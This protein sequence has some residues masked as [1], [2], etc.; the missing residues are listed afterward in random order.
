LVTPD[1]GGCFNVDGCLQKSFQSK[2]GI[3]LLN[4]HLSQATSPVVNDYELF[5]IDDYH[6]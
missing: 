2:Q 6:F 5:A 4:E 1:K 3:E